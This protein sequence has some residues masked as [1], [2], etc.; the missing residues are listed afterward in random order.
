MRSSLYLDETIVF[1][2][3]EQTVETRRDLR[4]PGVLTIIT[5]REYIFNNNNNH[6]TLSEELSI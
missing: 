5:Y 1:D 6:F 2:K 3:S 4:G